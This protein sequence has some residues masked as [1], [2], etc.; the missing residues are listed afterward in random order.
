MEYAITLFKSFWKAPVVAAKKDVNAPA[1]V[2]IIN[3]FGAYS[4]NGEHLTI[5]NTPAV[6][7]CF[8]CFFL[9]FYTFSFSYLKDRTIPLIF[10]ASR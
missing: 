7:F 1:N 8:M 5:K 10:S 9:R 3:T 4:N 6:H 2:I